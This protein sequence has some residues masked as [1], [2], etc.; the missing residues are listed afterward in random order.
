M[1]TKI[2]LNK[3]LNKPQTL[4]EKYHQQSKITSLSQDQLDPAKWP[5][6]WKTKHFK[7]YGRLEE[8]ILPKPQ[9]LTNISLKDALDYRSSVRKFSQQPLSREKLSTLLYYSAGLKD[10]Q[11]PETSARF[12]P[13]AGS[14]Y[15]LEVY[16]LSQNSDLPKGLYHYYLK[17]N[18][19]E[20]LIKL[21]KF[22]H[23]KYFNQ[24]WIA[25]AGC[26][27]IITA[28]FNRTTMKY[29]ERGY[30]HILIEAGHLGQNFYLLSSAL[31]LGCC[32]IGGYAD[33]KLNK[34][35]DI[36][37]IN[38][39]IIYVLAVG[40]AYKAQKHSWGSRPACAGRQ[41]RIPQG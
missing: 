33:D 36:D 15:P 37:G 8:L 16:L 2:D 5:K 35:L 3:L 28:V 7:G 31:D 29:G 14:R 40:S 25:K 9:S 21:D 30:R 17:N 18:S 24:E 41:I 4:A 39:A 6:E 38:E 19:L 10:I 12:Y 26:L 22:D 32:A 1:K 20:K 34:L 11:K 13:S 23:K 27:I